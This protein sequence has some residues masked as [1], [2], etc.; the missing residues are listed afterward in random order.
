MLASVILVGLEHTYSIMRT[1]CTAAVGKAIA[2]GKE[3]R[4]LPQPVPQGRSRLSLAALS[5]H[6]AQGQSSSGQP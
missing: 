4:T 1:C 6:D 5:D 2:I 3:G